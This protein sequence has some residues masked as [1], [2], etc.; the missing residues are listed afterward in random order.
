MPSHKDEEP[1]EFKVVDRRKFTAEGEPRPDA[2]PVPEAE[3]TPSLPQSPAPQAASA[4]GTAQPMQQEPPVPTEPAPAPQES[5]TS[6]EQAS[7]AANLAG[8]VQF[9][10]LIMSLVTQAMLQLGLTTR[11]GELAPKPDMPAAHET[12]DIL[13]ILQLKTKGNL[14]M[15]EDQLLTGSLTELRMAYVELTRR[16]A[17]RIN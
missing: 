17:G 15:Q 11:P 16:A 12:I 2:D 10:H 8:G 14:T 9:E 5:S 13:G 6:A 4:P 1:V 3:P 7:Q